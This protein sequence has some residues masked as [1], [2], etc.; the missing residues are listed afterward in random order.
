MSALQNN[1]VASLRQLFPRGV[2]CPAVVAVSGGIDSMVLLD[3]LRR[4]AARENKLRAG[5]LIACYV[6]HGLR[7]DTDKDWAIID[8]Y[9]RRH[10]LPFVVK[11][12]KP[13]VLQNTPGEA[14]L[15]AARYAALAD[16]ARTHGAEVIFTA[17]HANDNL[18]TFLLRLLRGA[19]LD[20][21]RGIPKKARRH[22][23]IIARPML[24]AKKSDIACYAAEE[25]L[26]WHEDSTNRLPWYARN[27]VRNELIPFLEVLRPRASEHLL[28]FF[29]DVAA[30]TQRLRLRRDAKTVANAKSAKFEDIRLI[31][32]SLDSSEGIDIRSIDFHLLKRAIDGLLGSHGHRTTRSHW[33]N[34]KIQLYKRSAT[35]TGGGPQKQIQFPGGHSACFKGNR[36]FWLRP[37]S[38]PRG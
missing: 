20:S 15:R 9:C 25:G 19:H 24:F 4:N 17:H 29:S 6:D 14:E 28:S 1:F 7:R 18:E 5:S 11:R 3:L 27:R 32:T 26:S 8:D 21:L 31:R 10:A 33:D 36:L 13:L 22:G 37:A 35:R 12:L 16:C 2:L 23:I 30:R 34:L 38:R